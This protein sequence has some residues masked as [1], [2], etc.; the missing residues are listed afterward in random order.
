MQPNTLNTHHDTRPAPVPPELLEALARALAAALIPPPRAPD[1]ARDG[2]RCGFPDRRAARAAAGGLP[3][4]GPAAGD[5]RGA[6]AH[7]RVPRRPQD[8]PPLPA[9]VRRGVR[10]QRPGGSRPGRLR[11]RLAGAGHRARHGDGLA[12]AAPQPDCSG[13]FCCALAGA[14]CVPRHRPWP[15]LPRAW[16]IGR[17]CAAGLRGVPGPPAVPGL[18]HHQPHH[19]RHLGRADR[20]GT[21]RAAV[22]LGTR[23]AARA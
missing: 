20:T 12:A 22:P 2:G 5:R 13:A 23:D 15:V 1:A 3:G 17:A 8:H 21:P 19:S 4:D 14:G 16:R 18:R 7:R 11:R 9:A 6:A 10:G